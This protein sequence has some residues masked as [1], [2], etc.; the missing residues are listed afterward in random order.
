[1]KILIVLL[2]LASGLIAFDSKADDTKQW[3]TESKQDG[4]EFIVEAVKIGAKVIELGVQETQ[5]YLEQLRELVEVPKLPGTKLVLLEG[6]GPQ[7]VGIVFNE[8][9]RCGVFRLPVAAHR[10]FLKF[11][12]GEKV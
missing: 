1:M 6:T 4:V 12:K 5:I 7:A 10:V 3:C 8:T 9:H 2:A 11:A